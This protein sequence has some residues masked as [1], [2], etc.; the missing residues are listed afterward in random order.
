MPSF[1]LFS[2]LF[3]S[4]PFTGVGVLKST[5]AHLSHP[6]KNTFKHPFPWVKPLVAEYDCWRNKVD[7]RGCNDVLGGA[8][9]MVICVG[10]VIMGNGKIV[11]K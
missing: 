3:T 11:L 5:P 9:V 8:L 4:K 1:A 6:L 7:C 10:V 2:I